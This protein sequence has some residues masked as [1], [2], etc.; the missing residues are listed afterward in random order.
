MSRDQKIRLAMAA[1]AVLLVTAAVL[2]VSGIFSGGTL[3]NVYADAEKYTAGDGEIPADIRSLSIDW[4]EGAVRIAY[5]ESN[6]VVIHEETEKELREEDRVHWYLDGDVLRIHYVRSG[7][8]NTWNLRKDLTVTLPNDK[9][10]ESGVLRTVSGQLLIPSLTAEHLEM[11][12]VSGD[13]RA[14]GLKAKALKAESVSGCIT[15][16][17]EDAEE[18]AA[19]TTSGSIA[20]ELTG[21]IG[22]V[23]LNSVSGTIAA[24]LPEQPGFTAR[25]STVSGRTENELPMVRKGEEYTCGDGSGRVEI[26]TVSGGIQIL[27]EGTNG[28]KL[29]DE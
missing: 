12:S 26:A 2:S 17:T 23:R 5:H 29:S 9:A 25:I 20:L 14:E 10:L 21:S 24:A 13:I 18:I 28:Q 11:Y 15:L 19:D 8:M 3:G 1:C 22:Q 7:K 4:P 27:R 16:R 6:T